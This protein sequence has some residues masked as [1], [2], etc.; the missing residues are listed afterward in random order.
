MPLVKATLGGKRR[1][2]ICS[3]VNAVSLDGS[4]GKCS[5]LG[6][7]AFAVAN[8]EVG[9]EQARLSKDYIDVQGRN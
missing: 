1:T 2:C 4:M 8:A 5:K 7:M 9:V 3:Q 6:G